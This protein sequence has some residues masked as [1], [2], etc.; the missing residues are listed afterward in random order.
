MVVTT[1]RKLLRTIR[2]DPSDTFVYERAAAPAEWAV[3]GGFIFWDH[4]PA[5]LAGREKQAFR[6][7]I[8]GLTSFGWSTLAVVVEATDIERAEAV[9]SLAG[10]LLAKHGA[11]D[12]AAALAAA[13]DEI[14]FAEQLAQHPVQTLVAL[15]RAVRDDGSVSEQFRTFHAADARQGSQ[16]PCSAGAFAI[17]E[18]AE[19]AGAGVSG[20]DE[21]DLAALATSR[22]EVGKP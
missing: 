11:P 5:K 17:I 7:G 6:A 1:T 8:L 3:P 9:A 20:N 4:D 18:E 21:I 2:L 10:H 15:H 22:A 14:A 12:E 16:M 13:E 19:A